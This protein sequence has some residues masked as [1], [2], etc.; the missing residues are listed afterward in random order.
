M[1]PYRFPI[2]VPLQIFSPEYIRKVIN[3]DQLHFV[4]ARKKAQLKTKT[5]IGPFICNTRSTWREVDVL[6]KLMNFKLSFT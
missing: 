2:Y 3:T 5:Q 6:L 1:P 4:L